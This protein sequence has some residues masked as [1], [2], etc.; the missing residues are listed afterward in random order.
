M[1]QGSCASEHRFETC[2]RY[3]PT[4][5]MTHFL[6]SKAAAVARLSADSEVSTASSWQDV[7]T[8][9]M[10]NW[11]QSDL[12]RHCWYHSRHTMT[13]QEALIASDSGT[14]GLGFCRGLQDDDVIAVLAGAYSL[15]VLRPTAVDG[16]YTLV[17]PALK[18]DL[19]EGQA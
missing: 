7:V 4:V 18:P 19:I 12:T 10:E 11:S 16:T 9:G 6:E 5:S 15:L 3:T 17:G 2:G 13:S 1:Q 14:L 8:E